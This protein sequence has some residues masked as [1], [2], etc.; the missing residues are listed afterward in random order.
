MWRVKTVDW[1]VP[2]STQQMAETAPIVSDITDCLLVT[3]NCFTHLS[4]N[5]NDNCQSH[6]KMISGGILNNQ[7]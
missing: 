1:T 6:L 7:I 5:G 4:I 3:A 2:K